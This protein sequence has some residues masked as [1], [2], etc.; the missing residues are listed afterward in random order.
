MQGNLHMNLAFKM[1]KAAA[2]A[3][4]AAIHAFA[5]QQNATAFIQRCRITK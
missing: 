5:A 3:L 2:A 4:R 1:K